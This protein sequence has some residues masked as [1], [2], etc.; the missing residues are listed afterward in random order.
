MAFRLKQIKTKEVNMN[1]HTTKIYLTVLL[2]GL[3]L[4]PM[5][6]VVA[7]NQ[8]NTAE[9]L[10]EPALLVQ[11]QDS[12]Q[13]ADSE[14]IQYILR[15]VPCQNPKEVSRIIW[16]DLIT[17]DFQ[18]EDFSRLVSATAVSRLRPHPLAQPA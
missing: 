1:P 14:L 18:E 3:F 4:L 6:P 11:N 8:G 12:Q 13:M 17:E 10:S 7:S 15:C 2:L 16:G 5:S 9:T